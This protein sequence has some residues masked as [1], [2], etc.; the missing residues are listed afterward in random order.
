MS[1]VPDYDAARGFEATAQ[2]AEAYQRAGGALD[3]GATLSETFAIFGRRFVPLVL[4]MLAILIP[5]YIVAYGAGYAAASSGA[6]SQVMIY[7]VMGI[8]AIVGAI[9]GLLG[10][11]AGIVAVVDHLSNRPFALGTALSIVMRRLPAILGV[12]LLTTL[13]MLLGIV[14][15]VIPGFIVMTIFYVAV[16]ACVVERV[17]AT[18]SLG[19][20]RF[21]TKGQRWRIFAIV[22]LV[23]LASAALSYVVRLVAGPFGM[24]PRLVI[25]LLWRS[26]SMA[27]GA[28]L[29][30]VVYYRLRMLKEGVD[31]A[32][33]ANVFD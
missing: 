22:L 12:T 8:S 29:S 17:G 11:S 14:L 16:P 3:I 18:Q 4:F 24:I 10:Q 31:I 32:A 2:Q 21:L 23:L 5:L 30:A 20:S 33:I 28:V 25:D 6:A 27:F 19:R 9:A 1:H 7:V 13:A 15:L 26:V